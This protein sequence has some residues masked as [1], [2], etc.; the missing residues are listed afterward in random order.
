MKSQVREAEVQRRILLALGAEPDLF[1]LVNSVGRASYVSDQ[2]KP[3]TVPYG[4]G[5]GSPD[6]VAM[7]TGP[8][9]LARWL[10]IEVKV[11]G[12]EPRANQVSAHKLWRSR[13]ALVYVCHSADEALAALADARSIVREQGARKA[14]AS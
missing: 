10:A 11:P 9:G 8:D 13:G 6:L 12:E 1:I 7:L 14:V 5:E 2:G 3:Y 4:L